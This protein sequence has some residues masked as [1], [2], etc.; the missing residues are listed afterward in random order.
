MLSA[1]TYLQGNTF[2]RLG[3]ARIS[4]KG[5]GMG[6]LLCS[7]NKLQ[8]GFLLVCVSRFMHLPSDAT[9]KSKNDE[10]LGGG[11]GFPICLPVLMCVLAVCCNPED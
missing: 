9:L 3:T 6:N 4:C 2:G 7:L 5:T 10:V 8:P 11:S 1:V